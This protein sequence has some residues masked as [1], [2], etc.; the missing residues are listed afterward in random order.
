MS[1]GELCELLP[2]PKKPWHIVKLLVNQKLISLNNSLGFMVQLIEN[3][4]RVKSYKCY[5]NKKQTSH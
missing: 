3:L 4:I 2:P 1:R 5:S